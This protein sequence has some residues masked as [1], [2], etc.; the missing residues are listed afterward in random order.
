M[1]FIR[2]FLSNHVLAN[3]TFGL[4]ILLGVVSYFQMP[5]AKDPEINFNWVNIITV[6]PGAA[7]VDIERRITDPLEESLR[8]S[9]KDMKFVLSTSRDSI[10]NILVRFNQIDE[11]LFDKRLIDLRREVQNTYTDELPQDAEDPVVY[12]IGTSN[13]FPTA[14]IVVTSQGDD[15]NLRRQARNIKKD[16]ERIR[17]VDRVDDVGLSDRLVP[18]GAQHKGF[19][20]IVDVDEV[21]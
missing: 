17:G 13:A 5:R 16:L 11:R 6:F 19:A 4:V 10:S 2:R 15:E 12:E 21:V 14:M 18:F 3:L 1:N 8:R 7:A 20:Q 9:V